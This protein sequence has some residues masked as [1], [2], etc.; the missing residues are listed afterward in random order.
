MDVSE[1]TLTRCGPRRSPTHNDIYELGKI[2]YVRAL[3]PMGSAE[4][5]GKSNFELASKSL[6]KLYIGLLMAPVFH[7][8]H[9]NRSARLRGCASAP[10][11]GANSRPHME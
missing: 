7:A 8:H 3:K 5:V 2:E 1:D 4:L 10:H 11:S 6:A 9:P